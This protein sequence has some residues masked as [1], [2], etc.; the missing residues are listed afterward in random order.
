MSVIVNKLKKSRAGFTLAETLICVLILL[1]VSAIVGAAIPTAANVYKN[2]VDAANAQVLLSTTMTA[3]R[4]EFSTAKQVQWTSGTNTVT[5]YNG[6][7]VREITAYGE[8]DTRPDGATAPGVWVRSDK[9]YDPDNPGA[10]VEFN[11]PA[12]LISAI[13]A[14]S[15]MYVVFTIDSVSSHG[16]ITLKDIQVFKSLDGKADQELA[17]QETYTIRFIGSP[18]V[19]VTAAPS[20]P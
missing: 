3:L 9:K 15:N 11:E 12:L 13:A 7:G 17:K 6:K 4:D 1:M 10:P 8:E 20:T 5:I 14:T 19:K 2:T 16:V 18:E